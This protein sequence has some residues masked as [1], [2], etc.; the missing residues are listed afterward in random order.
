MK[1]VIAT[2]SPFARKARVALI[3]KGLAHETVVQNPWQSTIAE[4]PLGKVPVLILDDGTVIHDS[5]VIVEYLETLSAPPRLIPDDARQRVVHKQIEAIADGLC[6]AVVLI[7]TERS[8]PPDKQSPEWIA[9]QAR[10]LP[11]A[12]DELERL[13]GAGECFTEHGFGLAEIAAGCALGYLDLRYPELDWR[14]GRSR[15]AAL[16]KR[17]AERPSFAATLPSP[18]NLAI[19]V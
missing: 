10:K 18:Q 2:P 7:V 14:A 11:A 6:D 9:R 19:G 4:N 8:R 16:A 5:S 13:L 3:E 15:L 1:L 17:L 12:L